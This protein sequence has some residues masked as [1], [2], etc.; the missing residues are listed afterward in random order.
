MR[1]VASGKIVAMPNLVVEMPTN[2]LTLSSPRCNSHYPTTCQIG[3]QREG[4][5]ALLPKCDGA[6]STIRSTP[7]SAVFA[8]VGSVL[9]SVPVRGILVTTA[10]G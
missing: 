9:A 7:S 4:G 5:A 1:Q 6:D 10:H 3:A 2:G 8:I